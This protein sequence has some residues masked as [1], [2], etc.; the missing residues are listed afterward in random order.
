MSISVIT[1]I[2]AALASGTRSVGY[3]ENF[4]IAEQEVLNNSCDINEDGYYPYVIIEEIEQ[5]IYPYPIKEH[6]YEWNRT[7]QCYE[8]INIKP[9]RFKKVACFGLG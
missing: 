5:G 4:E 8:K 2:R 1:T 9:G 3:F 6:W 7:K